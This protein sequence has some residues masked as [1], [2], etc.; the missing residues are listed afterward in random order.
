MEFILSLPQHLSCINII[1]TWNCFCNNWIY[2]M[3][4]WQFDLIEK[5]NVPILFL[6]MC[7]KRAFVPLN[8]LNLKE[9]KLNFFAPSMNDAFLVLTFRQL[10]FYF[11]LFLQVR[12]LTFSRNWIMSK[13]RK[14]FLPSTN[15]VRST[16]CIR[17]HSR[18]TVQILHWKYYFIS[19]VVKV[20]ES[21]Y[22][23]SKQKKTSQLIYF[24]NLLQFSNP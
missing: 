11:P 13:S 6:N 22:K 7:A 1:C 24:F 3:K 8:A 10:T 18:L 4:E 23:T 21:N 17:I 19:N 20:P 14:H 12:S 15:E 2:K 9:K 16:T 5:I